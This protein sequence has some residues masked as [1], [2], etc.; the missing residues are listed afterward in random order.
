MHLA[1][2]C[3][4][5]QPES[6][7]TTVLIVDDDPK[8]VHT[9]TRYFEHA[10]FR[11]L[12][13]DNGVHALSLA[14]SARPSLVILDR[15]LPGVEGMTVCRVLREESDVPVILLTA[16]TAEADRLEGL[17]AGADDYVVKPFSPRELVARARAVLRRTTS[18]RPESPAIMELGEL[19][20]DPSQRDVRV[21][22]R[23]VPLT[24]TEFN[25]LHL[26]VRAPGR[27][28]TRRELVEALFGWDRDTDERAIDV[29]VKNLRRKLEP[30]RGRPV[31]IETVH[32]VGY[33]FA[34]QV[35]R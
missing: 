8:I 26:L 9:V 18:T 4:S 1:G 28:F 15:M 29:H 35:T 21:S 20:V 3:A 16:R 6:S 27:V 30:D 14:R 24:S 25:L 7:A 17:D 10:G 33:R 12:T 13:A 34:K 31:F 2:V 23:A 19:V 32:G 11:V 5:T 22:G